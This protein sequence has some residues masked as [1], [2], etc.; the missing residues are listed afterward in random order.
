MASIAPPDVIRS[1]YAE[2]VVTDLAAARWFYV[3]VLGLVVTAETDDAL[4]L[5]A[6][7]EYTHHS[8]VLRLGEAPALALLSYRVR[9]LQEV[10]AAEAYFRDL[11]VRVQRVP[12]GTTL[13]IGEAVR[14]EDPLGF[15]IEFFST[16]ARMS[17]G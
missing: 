13:G 16:T 3:D 2:L 17:S 7:E 4:Y 14:I 5:R 10:D 8:L 11:G 15:P 12:A 1:A 6:Y 9:G